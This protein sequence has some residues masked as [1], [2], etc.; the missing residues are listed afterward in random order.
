MKQE[1]IEKIRWIWKDIGEECERNELNKSKEDLLLKMKVAMFS[2]R[3]CLIS[4]SK[5]EART[6]YYTVLLRLA[7]AGV[8]FDLFS[9]FEKTNCGLS[10]IEGLKEVADHLYSAAD[11]L[12]QIKCKASEEISDAICKLDSVIL[13][14]EINDEQE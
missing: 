12:S 3:N 2:L 13:E 10:I 4:E 9:D 1:L 7:Q 11:E 8:R 5:I 6:E 14:M